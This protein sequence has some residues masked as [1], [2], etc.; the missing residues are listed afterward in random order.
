MGLLQPLPFLQALGV[1]AVGW[2]S[3]AVE[4]QQAMHM[5][6]P[7]IFITIQGI[8]PV[9][10][11]PWCWAGAELP[12]WLGPHLPASPSHPCALHQPGAA[13]GPSETALSPGTTKAGQTGHEPGELCP[14]L[15]LVGQAGT[16]AQPQHL[17]GTQ[18]PQGREDGH[19]PLA[20]SQGGPGEV[21]LSLCSTNH[22]LLH[23]RSCSTRSAC[24]KH[25]SPGTSRSLSLGSSLD[26]TQS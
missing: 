18:N 8:K 24:S 25:S 17:P 7:Q 23:I 10:K 6:I 15:L 21:P 9:V 26:C 19:S 2:W 13:T 16:K 5:G 1:V 20:G 22:L 3:Q 11:L 4:L 12:A 14:I